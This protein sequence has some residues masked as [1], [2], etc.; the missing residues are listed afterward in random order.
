[1]KNY[2]MK[3]W[4]KVLLSSCLVLVMVTGCKK[5]DNDSTSDKTIT[6]VVTDDA[7]FSLLEHALMRAGLTTTLGTAGAGSYTVFA[8]DNAAFT[9]AG[10]GTE[11]AIDALD[12]TEL[13]FILLY[14]VLGSEVV[15]S[16]IATGDNAATTMLSTDVA[17]ISKKTNGNV[18]INGAQ[19]TTADIDCNN[20][21]IHKINKVLM[22]PAGDIV[23]IASGNANLSYLVAA[24]VRASTGSTN[25]AAALSG[26]G[27]LTVFA[28]TNDAFIAAGFPTIASINAADPNT[29]A[30]ILTYHVVSARIF[31]CDLTNGQVAT[32]LNTGTVT[33]ATTSGVTVKG[34]GNTTASNVTSADIVADNGVVHVID[35]V[36]LP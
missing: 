4:F 7:N 11:A 22:P 18:F 32:T 12:Q 34:N 33:I 5:D 1:M 26:A 25:V 28:P 21:V 23:D 13:S 9:A 36:L 8:P 29:L 3:N 19:V 30:S 24:V 10:L 17:Y 31:S 20:G 14:H 16:A 2:R 6:Q 27:P 35:R 15:S